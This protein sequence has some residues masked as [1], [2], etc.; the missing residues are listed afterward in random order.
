MR[1]TFSLLAAS[2]FIGLLLVVSCLAQD[3]AMSRY[4]KGKMIEISDLLSG[5]QI[6]KCAPTSKR[7]AGTVS[8]VEFSSGQ[9]IDSFTLRTTKGSVSIHLSPELYD[10]RISKQD[11]LALPS[12]V[13]KGRK[14]TVDAY[15]CGKVSYAHYILSGIELD[16]L[17]MR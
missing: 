10:S 13:A 16:T 4:K 11:A 8:A 5:S 3:E 1:K 7:Y 14:I 12:L 17:G 2:L 15:R 6:E 9:I